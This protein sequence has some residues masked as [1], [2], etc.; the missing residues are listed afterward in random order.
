MRLGTSKVELAKL[1]LQQLIHHSM[2]NLNFLCILK[3]I[4]PLNF[5]ARIHLSAKV[6]RNGLNHSLLMD[7]GY[8]NDLL[9]K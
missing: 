2:L 5:P 7:R 4:G 6:E 8:T 9:H 3:T 1:R